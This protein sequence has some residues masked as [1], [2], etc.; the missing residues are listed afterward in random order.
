MPVER[1]KALTTYI[2]FLKGTS[3]GLFTSVYCVQKI[4]FS[5]KDIFFLS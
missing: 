4:Y 3:A 5:K 1:I 2:T